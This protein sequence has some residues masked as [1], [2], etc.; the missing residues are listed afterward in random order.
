MRSIG[1]S[2]LEAIGNTPL[3]CLDDVFIKCEYLNPSGSI[4]ARLAKYIVERAEK[5]GLLKKGMTIVEASS[6]NTGNAL[7]LVAAAK[8]YKMLVIMPEGYT[9]ERVAIS[10]AFGATVKLVGHFQ[11]NEACEFARKLGREKGYWSPSQFENEWNVEENSKWLGQE[12]MG[13]LPSSLTIDA[14]IQGVGTGGTLVGVGQALR[15]YHNPNLLVFAME[16]SESAILSCNEVSDHLIEGISDGFVP[17]IYKRHREK[18]DGVVQVNGLDA[19]NCMKMLAKTY[20][21][22]VG[23]SSGANFLAAQQLKK[24]GIKNVLTFFCDEGEKY[25]TQHFL[26]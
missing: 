8:G 11:V 26:L 14:I 2:I 12:I 4:K 19:V 9:N 5:E 10:K 17:E 7:S 3:L 23:P 16:P 24:R 18:V 1:K 25:I 6:G 15:K 13:Q 21:T 20:G 22:F